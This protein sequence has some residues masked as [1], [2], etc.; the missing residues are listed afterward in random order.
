MRWLLACLLL[1]TAATSTADALMADHIVVEKSKRMMKLMAGDSV[2]RY[3]R[4]SL[5]KA[6]KGPKQRE[7][8]LKT[9]EGVY[10]ISGRL[11][12]SK[13]HLALQISYPNEQDIENAR[14]LGVK[15]GGKIMIH[16]QPDD[17]NERKR[18][19]DWTHGCIAVSDVEIEE[20][21][22]LVPDGTPIEIRP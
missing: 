7:G 5:G 10:Y 14:K 17:I 3:Y 18:P 9:P 19:R 12:D 2:L 13:Y 20:I 6:P 21:W 15:P 16:G 22:R 1:L 8:D 11:Q 4:I